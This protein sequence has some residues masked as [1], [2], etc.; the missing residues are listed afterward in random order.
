MEYNLNTPLDKDTVKKLRIGDV[1]Y[2]SGKIIGIRDATQRRIVDEGVD[3][4]IDL[5][6]QVVLHTAPNA[7]KVNGRWEKICIGTTTSARMERYTP[8]LIEK[9]GISGVIGK[10]GLLEGSLKAMQEFGAVYFAIVGGAAA[11]ETLQ[12]E[13]IEEVFWEDLFPECLWV[14]KVKNLGPLLVAMDSY[15]N[16]IYNEILDVAKKRV[17]AIV[18]DLTADLVKV[19]KG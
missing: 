18:D 12:I 19:I 16:S 4:P 11:L 6:N 2:L 17:P 1:V 15:G 13:R 10:G 3:P 8:V 5:K 9:Y 14:F 7:K